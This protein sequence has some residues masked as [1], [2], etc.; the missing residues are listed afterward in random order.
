MLT[1][2]FSEIVENHAPLKKKIVRGN[3]APF[4]NK[5]LRKEI[6]TRSRLKNKLNKNPTKENENRY[7]QQRNKCVSLRRKS[8]KGYFNRIT[9]KGI[10]T[11]KN[12]WSIIR[13][14]LTNKG[15][16]S[17]TDITL[18]ENDK[19]VNDDNELAEILN[20]HYINIVE[21]SSRTKPN[22]IQNNENDQLAI[23]FIKN[24]FISHPSLQK[25]KINFGTTKTVNIFPHTS[26][27]DIK[28]LL[29]AIDPNKAT[30][31]DNIPPKLVKL[32]SDV[33]SAPLSNAI[34]NSLSSGIFPEKAKIAS[35]T[36]LDKGTTNK[37]TVS[38][39]RPVSI[40]STFSKIYEKVIKDQLILYM[41]SHFSE[42]LSGYRKLYGTQH[43]LIRLI[44]E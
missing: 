37:N 1:N 18:I 2:K 5:E 33:I 38:N 10:V 40:L 25:I 26:T 23:N 32:A 4:M 21:R 29:K 12:F 43:V 6:Y 24:S 22:K 34:N 15:I 11:N 44:E 9:N 13:P 39:F 19:I 8:I 17:G 42:F 14:F 31:I 27:S 36:P 35:V 28:M 20:D 16:I 3:N 30:G 41:N 7:K